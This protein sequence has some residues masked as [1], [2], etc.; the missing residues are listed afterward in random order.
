MRNP[1]DSVLFKLCCLFGGVN[2]AMRFRSGEKLLLWVYDKKNIARMKKKWPPSEY[3]CDMN[4]TR[5]CV[6]VYKLRC[7]SLCRFFRSFA[8]RRGF[9]FRS[10]LRGGKSEAIR[11]E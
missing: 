9:I 3:A 4:I 10:F 7:G 5:K 8:L 6:L 2:A 1:I 11:A